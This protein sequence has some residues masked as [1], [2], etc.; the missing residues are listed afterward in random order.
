MM[1]ILYADELY[2]NYMNN[3]RINVNKNKNKK[4]VLC[5]MKTKMN[6]ISEHLCFVIWTVA[7]E[8]ATGLSD[9]SNRIERRKKKRRIPNWI[10]ILTNCFRGGNGIHGYIDN[11]RP[12]FPLNI[13]GDYIG[14]SLYFPRGSQI[15]PCNRGP[16]SFWIKKQMSL[17]C[18][19]TYNCWRYIG[20]H[21]RTTLIFSY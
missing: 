13:S 9:G 12:N 10:N 15:C 21:R 17:I 19:S 4:N 8:K 7:K 6:R 5:A 11:C 3:L 14:F 2:D 18:Y 16:C 1:L 20:I